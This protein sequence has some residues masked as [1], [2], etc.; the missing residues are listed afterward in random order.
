MQINNCHKVE[1]RLNF[2]KKSIVSNIGMTNDA[3]TL[4]LTE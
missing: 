4:E 1:A 3:K 2:D